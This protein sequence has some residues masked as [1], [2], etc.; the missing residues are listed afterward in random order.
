MPTAEAAATDGAGAAA[1]TPSRLRASITA[2]LAGKAA[3]MV[4][5]VL[6][7]TLVPRVLGPEDYGRFAVPLTVVT[8]GSLAMTLGG[9]TLMARYV[10]AAP[11]EERV[12][13]A[14]AIG[15][16][17]ARGRAMQLAAVGLAA[18]AA[19][20][21][22]PE[23]F[24]PAET[25][26]VV[27]ALAINVGTS[28]ALQVA[29]GLGRAGAWSARYPLQNAALV[30]A[31]LVLHGS[32][33][34]TGAVAALVVAGLV[35]AGLAVVVVAPVALADMSPVTVPAGAIR[36]GALHAAGAALVQCAHRGG[37]VAV[38]VLVGSAVETG[39]SALAIGIAL[40]A[41]Y[42]VLQAFTVA[43][44]HLADGGR[45]SAGEADAAAPSCAGHA[46]A[47]AILR[48]LAGGLL[49]VLVPATLLA[50]VLLDTLVPAV[51]GSRYDG[52]TA[53]F[54]PALAV[55][56]LAPLSA[57][58]VQA[59][60]LRL[61]AEVALVSGV[62][63]ALVFLAGALVLVPV[64][65]AAGATGATL[66]GVAAGAIVAVR[67][68]PGAAGG[69]LVAASFLGAAAVLSVALVAA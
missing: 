8:L 10:P 62:A 5:L 51:F 45:G 4:T 31:V 30:A 37:V 63:T 29:L 52:A 17:L 44:P 58:L 34:T 61:R 12:A 16:R 22:E 38:A 20:V 21:W 67:R 35:A 42:A 2:S 36:F 27:A 55:V 15:G 68:L 39:Y 50:A 48:R 43:L 40:G 54:A 19:A 65:E 53:A 47:E 13:L 57:L 49:A 69:R 11:P 26:L 9:P 33:G 64:G 23:R 41:T 60:A 46:A 59:A 25:A 56:V 1:R 18:L 28:L 6:L 14:R 7:A 32:F 66:A 24:P 3:E